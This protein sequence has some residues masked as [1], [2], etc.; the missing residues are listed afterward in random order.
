[1]VDRL[2]ELYAIVVFVALLR[3]ADAIKTITAT[4][5]KLFDSDGDQFFI[6]GLQAFWSLPQ[7]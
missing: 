4:G 6:K 2:L 7:I 3:V 5:A 1:M